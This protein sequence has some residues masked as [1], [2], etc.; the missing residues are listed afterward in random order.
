MKFVYQIYWTCAISM[1]CSLVYI[2][3]VTMPIYTMPYIYINQNINWTGPP[4]LTNALYSITYIGAY[5]KY[6][7]INLVEAQG[8]V[9]NQWDILSLL[10][11]SCLSETSLGTQCWHLK[12]FF[13]QVMT[14]VAMKQGTHNQ[15]NNTVMEVFYPVWDWDCGFP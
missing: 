7:S 12:C 1:A 3:M 13:H 4:G 11:S 2:Y 9:R 15:Y 5:H 8:Q 14:T 10:N 6:A